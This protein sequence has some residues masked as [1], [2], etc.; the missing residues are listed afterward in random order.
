MA[1]APVPDSPPTWA[2]LDASVQSLAP[3]SDGLTAVA[4]GLKAGT[5]TVQLSVTV[6]GKTF[7]ATVDATI[8][9]GVPSQTLSSVGI[10]A[11]AAL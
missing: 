9:A 4:T 10:V 7:A 5:D 8:N 6:G 11:S 3:A 1:V 2:Q